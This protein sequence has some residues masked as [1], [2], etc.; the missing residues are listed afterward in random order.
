MSELWP[1]L[2]S[3]VERAKRATEEYW[4]K[5]PRFHHWATPW[6]CEHAPL[7]IAI[8]ART[9]CPGVGWYQIS[10]CGR[11]GWCTGAGEIVRESYGAFYSDE[12]VVGWDAADKAA[13]A[14]AEQKGYKECR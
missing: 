14:F 13:K 3:D 2:A 1:R 8:M 4:E 5:Q 7:R 11:G 12:G 9:P 6:L 10:W